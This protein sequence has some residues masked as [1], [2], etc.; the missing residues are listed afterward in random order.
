MVVLFFIFSGI[1]QFAIATA[2]YYIPTNS[3][4]GFQFVHIV[5]R[6]VVLFFDKNN[7]KR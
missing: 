4:Q 6:L 3:V 7:S 1:L 2:P 5:V